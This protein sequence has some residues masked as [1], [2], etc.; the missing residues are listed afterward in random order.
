MFKF[1]DIVLLNRP[2]VIGDVVKWH[3]HSGWTHSA[4]CV[5]V[6]GTLIEATHPRVRE[7]HINKYIESGCSY[8]VL[9]LNNKLNNE[10]IDE[11]K[12]L[13]FLVSQIGKPYDYLGF[14]SFFV[15]QKIGNKSYFFCSEL[16]YEFYKRQEKLITRSCPSFVSPQTLWESLAF[17]VNIQK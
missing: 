13:E 1:G 7:Y 2:G 5:D 9:R 4:L 3:T 6:T 16:I 14:L 11:L 10:D 8:A 15:N 12:G 17:D